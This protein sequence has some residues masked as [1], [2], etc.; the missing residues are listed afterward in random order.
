MKGETSVYGWGLG[1]VLV[2]TLVMGFGATGCDSDDDA[3]AQVSTDDLGADAWRQYRVDLVDDLDQA[4]VTLDT[5]GT[6]SELEVVFP[7]RFCLRSGNG[8]HSC[9][10]SDLHGSGFIEITVTDESGDG[11]SYELTVAT[12]PGDAEIEDLVVVDEGS[13]V[14]PM[15]ATGMEATGRLTASRGHAPVIAAILDR[16]RAQAKESLTYD[17]YRDNERVGM[18]SVD[19]R[20]R[21]QHREVHFAA[22]IKGGARPD[23]LHTHSDQPLVLSE[24][25]ATLLDGRIRVRTGSGNSE[26]LVGGATGTPADLQFLVEPGPAV[27]EK[28][29]EEARGSIIA[30]PRE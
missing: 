15:A 26:V 14:A 18:A 13:G 19:I 23:G 12:T 21:D 22:R 7:G 16:A 5:D 17:L 29:L 4:E 1:S 10:E 9:D 24:A 25:D 8:P 30:R 2:L 6:V 28:D 20:E 11:L 27:H 3:E